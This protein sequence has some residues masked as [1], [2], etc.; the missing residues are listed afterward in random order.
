MKFEDAKPS[1][2]SQGP[3]T[4]YSSDAATPSTASAAAKVLLS[5]H[6]QSLV[7][8]NA[9]V[10]DELPVYGPPLAYKGGPAPDQGLGRRKRSDSVDGDANGP[11]RSRR[12]PVPATPPNSPVPNKKRASKKVADKEELP[13]FG[14]PLAYKGGP[15][16]E[17][18]LGR[19]KRSDSVDGGLRKRKDFVDGGS[20]PKRSRPNALPATPPNSPVPAKKRAPKKV[21]AKTDPEPKRI[22]RSQT[23]KDKPVTRSQTKKGGV[24]K[25]RK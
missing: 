12:N 15:A 14:P 8:Q 19:R 24:Q 9:D 17:Q 25:K 18:G 16:P 23:K 20:D 4:V 13:Q 11:K 5:T 1:Q 7:Q 22:T 10:V 21:V 3:S 6:R 2:E